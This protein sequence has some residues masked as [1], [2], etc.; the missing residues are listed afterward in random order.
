MRRYK[1]KFRG[2]D[3]EMKTTTCG[4]K[5]TSICGILKIWT[6][7]QLCCLCSARKSVF[8]LKIE[9]Q[10]SWSAEDKGGAGRIWS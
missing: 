5:T 3:L 6:V 9:R 1:N 8:S 4:L 2:F 10:E 7:M